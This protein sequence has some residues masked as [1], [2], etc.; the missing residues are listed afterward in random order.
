M[1]YLIPPLAASLLPGCAPQQLAVKP[2]DQAPVCAVK[3]GERQ[4]YWNEAVARRDG[5]MV[6]LTGECP[7]R[8][9]SEGGGGG[10]GGM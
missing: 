3:A 8:P 2:N 6:L 7:T 4:S 1:R 10:S 5:A 9:N